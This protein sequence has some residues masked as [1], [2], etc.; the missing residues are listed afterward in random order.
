[1]NPDSTRRRTRSDKTCGGAKLQKARFQ[2]T[3]GL[4]A[5]ILSGGV[6]PYFELDCVECAIESGKEAFR[7]QELCAW[8]REHINEIILGLELARYSLSHLE[9]LA[10]TENELKA[11]RCSVKEWLEAEGYAASDDEVDQVLERLK[12]YWDK[13]DVRAWQSAVESVDGVKQ[14]EDE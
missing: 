14:F 6:S 5:I 13:F 12:G 9:E 11:L 4:I 10:T 3:E 2:F 1:M 7:K 8:A